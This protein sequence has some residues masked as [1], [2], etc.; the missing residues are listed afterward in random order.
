MV[1]DTTE[2]GQLCGGDAVQGGFGIACNDIPRVNSA[3]N[4]ISFDSGKATNSPA[5]PRPVVTILANR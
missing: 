2:L 1:A 4:Y 3:L 5:L